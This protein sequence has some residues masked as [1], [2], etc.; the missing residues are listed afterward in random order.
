M[1]RG[2][3]QSPLHKVPIHALL[4]ARTHAKETYPIGVCKQRPC[5]RRCVAGYAIHDARVWCALISAS[6]Y[7][8]ISSVQHSAASVGEIVHPEAANLCDA[9]VSSLSSRTHINILSTAVGAGV[10]SGSQIWSRGATLQGAIYIRQG[11][12]YCVCVTNFRSDTCCLEVSGSR[13]LGSHAKDEFRVPQGYAH[14]RPLTPL[15][16]FSWWHSANF[17]SSSTTFSNAETDHTGS[18][19]PHQNLGSTLRFVLNPNQTI[20]PFCWAKR[21]KLQ[22]PR[23]TQGSNLMEKTCK[24]KGCERETS[25]ANQGESL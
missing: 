9:L 22:T 25:L 10:K 20:A 3:K 18:P 6:D 12:E 2:L 17:F 19:P 15:T 4:Q 21:H 13:H 23:Q 5:N 8:L 11:V 14:P 16:N 7:T 24:T 1:A